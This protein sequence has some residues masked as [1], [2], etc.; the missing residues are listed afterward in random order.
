MALG[1]ATNNSLQD[2]CAL[3]FLSTAVLCK[4]FKLHHS[5]ILK[6]SYPL[7][8]ID[9]SL[10]PAFLITAPL[11]RMFFLLLILLL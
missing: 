3:L 6:H 2:Q 8:S 9:Y 4:H 10:S 11:Q 7:G 1:M 5:P